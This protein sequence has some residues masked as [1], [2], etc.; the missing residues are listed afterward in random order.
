MKEQRQIYQT[1]IL[2]QGNIVNQPN[3]FNT[4][5]KP[6]F[7]QNQ[8]MNADSSPGDPKPA[9]GGAPAASGF[10]DAAPKP[11]ASV[12]TCTNTT[13]KSFIIVNQ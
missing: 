11:P 6:Q 1:Q 7:Q 8:P 9:N 12:P 10:Q 5:N 4:Y 13:N 3:S 2:Q